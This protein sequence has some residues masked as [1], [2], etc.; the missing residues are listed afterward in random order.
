[1][2]LSAS[3][4]LPINLSFPSWKPSE[5]ENVFPSTEAGPVWK[6]ALTRRQQSVG[7]ALLQLCP[8]ETAVEL[9]AAFEQQFRAWRFRVG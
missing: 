7:L 1:M 2:E 9:Q 6:G 4:Y 5:G 3:I 8:E